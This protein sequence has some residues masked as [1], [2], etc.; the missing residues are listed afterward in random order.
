MS[1]AQA[2]MT[3]QEMADELGVVRATVTRWTHDQV[4]P[5]SVVLKMWALRTGVPLIWLETGQAPAYQPGPGESYT[6]RDS[7]PEP[8]DL[9]SRR[10]W[11]LEAA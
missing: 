7:N 5:K 8:I 9:A 6:A 2:E 1:L 10:P 3:A 4:V 11:T